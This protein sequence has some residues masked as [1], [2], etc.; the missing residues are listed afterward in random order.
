VNDDNSASTDELIRRVRSSANPRGSTEKRVFAAVE[1]RLG[2]AALEAGDTGTS[3]DV[4]APSNGAAPG[5]AAVGRGAAR[6]PVGRTVSLARPE[7]WASIGAFGLATGALGYWW[8]LHAESPRMDAAAPPV[9]VA[10]TAPSVAAPAAPRAST[11]SPAPPSSAPAFP[12]VASSP[13]QRATPAKNEAKAKQRPRLASRGVEHDR[14]RGATLSLGEAIALL[15]RAQTALRQGEPGEALALLGTLEGRA[16]AQL[17]QQELLVTRT[18]ALCDLEDVE[19][20]R[21]ALSELKLE[22]TDSIYRSRLEASC[23]GIAIDDER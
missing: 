4:V 6:T 12:D 18:L 14:A 15:Q 8:G 22:E 1:R 17:V 19:G 9:E 10:A 23:V 3:D 11:A 21:S 7:L 13:P 16:P 20:A 5:E 2:L